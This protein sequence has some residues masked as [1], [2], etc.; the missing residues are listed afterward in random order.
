MTSVLLTPEKKFRMIFS[1][2]IEQMK[3]FIFKIPTKPRYN[4]HFRY[5]SEGKYK[6]INLAQDEIKKREL[7]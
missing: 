6:A 7:Y 4:I 3:S 2:T 1:L 5:N